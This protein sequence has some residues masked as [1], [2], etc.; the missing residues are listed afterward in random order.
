[1]NHRIDYIES[2]KGICMLLVVMVHTG[3]PE[4]VR[5]LYDLDVPAFFVF[6]G[7]FFRSDV[8]FRT[9]LQKKLRRLAIPFALFYLLSYAVYYSLLAVYPAAASMTEASGIMD[10]MTQRAWFNGPLWFLPCLLW[11]QLLSYGLSRVP[12]VLLRVFIASVFG[13]CGLLLAHE[14]I[15]LPMAIDTSLTAFPYFYA[16]VL[17][18]YYGAF[19]LSRASALG[20]CLLTALLWLFSRRM[21]IGLSICSYD[22]ELLPMYVLP[23]LF[24]LALVSVSRHLLC[25]WDRLTPFVGRH[26]MY[27]LCIHHLVYRPVKLA[28]MHVVGDVT[29]PYVTF[30]VTM[31]F[32]LLTAPWV[33][34]RLPWLLGLPPSSS[35]TCMAAG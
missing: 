7:F 20:A 28:V 15:F 14:G 8:G 18:R 10:C 25:P 29:E 17:C 12:G 4:P 35:S 26:T 16:G 24:S 9:L 32:C 19:S 21:S 3:V 27:V 34:Q 13:A 6:S 2:A 23:M 31:L 22:A 5:D 1:M 33:T 30:I 11:M